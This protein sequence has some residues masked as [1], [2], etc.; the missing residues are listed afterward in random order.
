MILKKETIGLN[1]V[2]PLHI[3]TETLNQFYNLWRVS[4]FKETIVIKW[5]ILMNFTLSSKKKWRENKK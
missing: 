1:Y 2:E 5:C 4:V 3:V